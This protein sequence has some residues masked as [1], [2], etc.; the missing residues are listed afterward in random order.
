MLAKGRR[1]SPENKGS[2]SV[3]CQYPQIKKRSYDTSPWITL[4]CNPNWPPNSHLI[5]A[6]SDALPSSVSFGLDGG[7]AGALDGGA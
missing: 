3:E 5:G 6:V 7:D 1:T 4:G 2:V